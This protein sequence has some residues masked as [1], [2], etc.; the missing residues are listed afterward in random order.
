MMPATSQL[1]N[2][3]LADAQSRYRYSGGLNLA[4]RSL[5]KL[6]FEPRE[7][8]WSAAK[9]VKV[10]PEH[11]CTG[12]SDERLHG[13]YMIEKSRDSDNARDGSAA[14]CSCVPRMAIIAR[15]RR[16]SS[17]SNG[18][19]IPDLTPSAL[20]EGERLKGTPP[21]NGGVPHLRHAG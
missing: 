8:S 3:R 20:I 18:Q 4:F 7:Y 6:G 1:S 13:M 10:K 12:V 17:H 16:Q 21:K 5:G 11:S 9:E 15:Q 14:C 19:S 2:S